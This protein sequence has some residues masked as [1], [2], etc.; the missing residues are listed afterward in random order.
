[1]TELRLHRVDYDQAPRLESFEDHTIFQTKNWLNYVARTQN[2]EP[3][4]AVIKDGSRPVGRFTGL[5]M[6]RYGL[7]ILGSP[8]PGWMTFY[9]GFNLEPSYSRTDALL[10][11]KEF[12]F[13]DLRC[14]HIEISDR[15]IS[16]EQYEQAGYANTIRTGFEI[17]LTKDEDELFAAMKSA[18]RRCIRKASKV[19]VQVEAATDSL[20]A[21]DYYAQ[22]QNVF[23][24]QQ[25]VPPY[26]KER[27][28]TLIDELLPTGNLLLVRA[29]DSQ[30][31]CIASR[32]RCRY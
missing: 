3:V 30:G 19:G 21:D 2:A 32:I 6:K 31:L 8:A 25:V 10:A 12:A 17:D 23:A 24:R 14:V 4:I 5:I 1:M 7:R 28:Q 22:L 11:L 9:M 15:R 13:Q 16:T 18:C 27:V 20:F 26:P 29:R